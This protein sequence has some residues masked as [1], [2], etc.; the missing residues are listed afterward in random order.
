MAENQNGASR[1]A[2][3]VD[4]DEIMVEFV[5]EVLRKA[6]YSVET[7]GDGMTALSMFRARPFDVAIVDVRMPKLSGISFLQN[8]RLP[9]NSPHRIVLLSGMDDSKLRREAMAA[10]AAVYLVKPASG[11]AILA[12]ASGETPQ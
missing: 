10:G 12:A 2:L 8:L 5:S 9:P 3:V 1:R 7:C 6:G 4:D 11:K